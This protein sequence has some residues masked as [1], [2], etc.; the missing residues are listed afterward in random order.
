MCADRESWS[1]SWL[2]FGMHGFP[3]CDLPEPWAWRKRVGCL[4]GVMEAELEYMVKIRKS[5]KSIFRTSFES[6]E[7]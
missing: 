5:L 1:V 3:A 4:F 7:R 6:T 2:R